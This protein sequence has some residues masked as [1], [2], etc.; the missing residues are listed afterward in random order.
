MPSVNRICVSISSVRVTITASRW[1]CTNRTH[2]HETLLSLPV[3]ADFFEIDVSLL[4]VCVD[5]LN[6]DL[7]TDIQTL[8]SV[9]QLAFNGH[10]KKT[11]PR[12]LLGSTG[13]DRVEPFSDPSWCSMLNWPAI[14]NGP[15]P[16]EALAAIFRFIS[17]T[18]RVP[19]SVSPVSRV[20]GCWHPAPRRFG[21][22]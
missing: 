14:E 5:Q 1:S 8:E 18:I 7:F 2:F 13:D 17:W 12:S 15:M 19:Y 4:D 20:R 22:L 3:R 10:G 21:A 11:D 6:P 9:H 16:T